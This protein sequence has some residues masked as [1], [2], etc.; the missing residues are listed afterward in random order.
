MTKKKLRPM[1]AGEHRKVSSLVT[2][3]I[4]VIHQQADLEDFPEGEEI[5]S[6][7][8]GFCFVYSKNINN[9]VHATSAVIIAAHNDLI[10]AG[11]VGLR[12]V[13]QAMADSRATRQ[14]MFVV[15]K[16]ISDPTILSITSLQREVIDNI[17]PNDLQRIMWLIRRRLSGGKT[18]LFAT[19]MKKQAVENLFDSFDM[20]GVVE[21]SKI[22]KVT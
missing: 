9:A 7:R 20:K 6:E 22:V 12:S 1:T 8:P 18:T 21:E 13:A 10:L 19:N 17:F 15:E 2:L 14:P 11:Q 3:G 4:P 5:L 16:A